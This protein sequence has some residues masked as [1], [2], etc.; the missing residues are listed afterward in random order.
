MEIE[1]VSSCEEDLDTCPAREPPLLSVEPAAQAVANN[2]RLSGETGGGTATVTA[3]SATESTG[4]GSG[5]MRRAET[6]TRHTV[7]QARE[8][9]T[10]PLGGDA[11]Q[12]VETLPGA[13]ESPV[14]LTARE[15]TGVASSPTQRSQTVA[16]PL[17]EEPP[18]HYSSLF[19]AAVTSSSATN[20]CQP[21][22]RLGGHRPS[23]SIQH[24]PFTQRCSVC[25]PTQPPLSHNSSPY[26]H[27]HHH[28][29]HTGPALPGM[30]GQHYP[31][32]YPPRDQAVS[33][34]S[35]CTA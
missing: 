24:P 9:P 18:P 14:Q 21:Q 13:T 33:Q 27:H 4:A 10:A 34:S 8:I 26:L 28:L 25:D 12:T 6:S 29:H 17:I 1:S 35:L 32:H 19:P 5:A 22:S 2:A 23:E 20:N 31:E 11:R 15:G 3:G 30:I 7:G 16:G